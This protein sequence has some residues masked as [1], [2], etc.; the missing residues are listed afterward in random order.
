M[1]SLLAFDQQLFLQING[2]SGTP[3]D[4]I[5]IALTWFGKIL[6]LAPLGC[7]LMMQLDKKKGPQKV[8]LFLLTVVCME[9][10]IHALKLTFVRTRPYAFFAANFPGSIPGH[11][12]IPMPDS[13]SFPSGHAAMSFT[14]A[15]ILNFLYQGRLLY[16]YP[17]AFLIAFS[18]IYLGVHFPSDVVTGI[19][20]GIFGGFLLGKV[21]KKFGRQFL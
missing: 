14:V 12:V 19:L 3:F 4:Q 2:W 11:Y 20:L 9:I 13:Y 1:E 21:F 10:L 6:I 5:F 16:L 17:V 7:V 8:I 15:Y 18:R